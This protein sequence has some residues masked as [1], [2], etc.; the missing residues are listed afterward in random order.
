MVTL[1]ILMKIAHLKFLISLKIRKI[2]LTH[3][4]ANLV[5]YSF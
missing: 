2:T 4:I 1:D 3:F 5:Y